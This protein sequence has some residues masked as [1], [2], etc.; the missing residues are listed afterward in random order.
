MNSIKVNW[1]DISLVKWDN[2]FEFFLPTDNPIR[3]ST[4]KSIL[5]RT[6]T[7]PKGWMCNRSSQSFFKI[8]NE[9][10]VS[11]KIVKISGDRVT[12]FVSQKKVSHPFIM[13]KNWTLSELERAIQDFDERNVC[14]GILDLSSY[15]AS[16]KSVNLTG[17]LHSPDCLS[18]CEEDET[19]CRCC[20]REEAKLKQFKQA[21]SEKVT[22]LQKRLKVAQRRIVRFQHYKS[23]K[24][25]IILCPRIDVNPLYFFSFR[26]S[27]TF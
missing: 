18:I 20:R 19:Q 1:V 5:A 26:I 27:A 10:T 13:A 7:L 24:I 25:D 11:N 21:Q 12:F 4:S 22:S 23:V 14:P 8:P 17:N 9:D 6:V 3:P 15:S 2:N 16:K